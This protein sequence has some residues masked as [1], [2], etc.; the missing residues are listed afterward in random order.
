[1]I[2]NLNSGRERARDGRERTRETE[3]EV[4]QIMKGLEC[5]VKNLDLI[6]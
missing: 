2:W 6:L 1:M 4:G 5:R 3:R